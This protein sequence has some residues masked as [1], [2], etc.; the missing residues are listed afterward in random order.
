VAAAAGEIGH[1]GHAARV[2]LELLVV[3]APDMGVV[4][5]HGCTA[6]PW[7]D[8]LSRGRASDAGVLEMA[9]ERAA[10]MARTTLCAD[11][12]PS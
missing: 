8:A 6:L 12:R 5:D 3:Q 4:V 1:E 11:R 2:V 9:R 10:K 7:W